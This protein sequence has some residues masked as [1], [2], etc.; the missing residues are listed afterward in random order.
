MIPKETLEK[1]AV[2]YQT[3]IYPNVVREYLQHLFLSKLYTLN[4]S[5]NLLFKGGTALRIAYNSPRFSED[6]DFTIIQLPEYQH[7]EFTESSFAD[8]LSFIESVGIKTELGAKPGPTKKGYYGE[9]T[10]H[11][12]DYA[13]VVVSINVSSR[14]GRATS[15]E[16]ESIV[17]DFVPV[18]NLYRMKEADLID[19][20]IDALL[21]R[22][23]ARDFYDVYFLMR[24]NLLTVEQRKRLAE[25]KN[26]AENESMNFQTELSVFL[27]VSQQGI[28]R[29]FR[30]T[31][32]AEINRQTS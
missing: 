26:L 23:K 25:V 11:V 9:A 7:K 28:I 6:L 2:Q 16:I 4:D 30:T 31:L 8:V 14:Q 1:L 5:S 27:P 20:K 24:K 22:K 10:F 18:Y 15:G 3:T 29:D 19:E 12:Y 13:P 32:L 17:N 21:D